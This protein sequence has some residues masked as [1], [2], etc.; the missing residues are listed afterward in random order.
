MLLLTG[1]ALG[2][3]FGRRRIFAVGLALFIAASAACA[4]SRSAGRLIAA[5][6]AQGIGAALV[7]PLAMALLSAAFPREERAKAL[8]IFGGITGHCADRRPDRRRRD[9]GGIRLALDLLDQ[10]ADRPRRPSRSM[11]GRIAESRGPDTALDIGGLV[12]VTGA[13][14]AHRVGPDARAA[15]AGWSSREVARSARR[16]VCCSPSPSSA[17]SGASARR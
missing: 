4:L 11:R 13:A 9:R 10:P 7:M 2:D 14:L 16:P 15:S 8:G 3:R 6:A 5:R 17:S 12:L 1:A